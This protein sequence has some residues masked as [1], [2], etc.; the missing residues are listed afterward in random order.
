M[1]QCTHTQHNN[2][3]GENY[4]QKTNV[5]HFSGILRTLEIWI[6]QFYRIVY[7][8]EHIYIL[9]TYTY[10]HISVSIY[11]CV[12]VYFSKTCMLVSL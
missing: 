9:A 12:H 8:T 7:Y 6:T 4:Y 5:K 11:L 1:P 2:K 10:V 3:I